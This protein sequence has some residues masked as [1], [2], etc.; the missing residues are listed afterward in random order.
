MSNAVLSQSNQHQAPAASG[1]TSVVAVILAAWLVAIAW[2]AASR[3][4]VTPPGVLPL[5]IAIGVTAPVLVFLGAYWV[6]RQFREFVLTADIRLVAAIHAWRAAGFAF[7]TLYA[8]D[9]LPGLF[10]L[11]AGLGDVAIG[12]TTPWIVLTL[13]RRPRFAAGKT[14]V[15]WNLLGLLDLVVA[16]G[17]GALASGFDIGNVG[18]IT[19]R[20]MALLP[21]VLI[22]AY[23]VPIFIMLHL[24]ALFQAR[25]VAS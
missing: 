22:P 21:L 9:V 14:F 20:P 8:Y 25:R 24:T 13:I 10:A 11:P 23:L 2:L 18:E 5:P 12:I 3:A 4:F 19:T 16:V 6:S 1:I 7:L 15:T 17:T